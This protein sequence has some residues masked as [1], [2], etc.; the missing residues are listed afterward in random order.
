MNGSPKP[1]QL[2]ESLRVPEPVPLALPVPEPRP[3]PVPDPESLPE[4]IPSLP[5]PLKLT[6]GV[7]VFN[8]KTVKPCTICGETSSNF[9]SCTR[10]KGG[11]MLCSDNCRREYILRNGNL[12]ID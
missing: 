9:L 4:P 1:F 8:F 10:Y 5:D 11:K 3:E 6:R 12:P 7:T 2:L